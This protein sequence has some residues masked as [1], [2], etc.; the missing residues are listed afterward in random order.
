LV[1]VAGVWIGDGNAVIPF[2][3]W[4]MIR[5]CHDAFRA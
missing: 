5:K 3:L 2:A 1:W 4:S